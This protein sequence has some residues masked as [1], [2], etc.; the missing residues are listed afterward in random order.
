MTAAA[1]LKKNPHPIDADIDQAMA[2]NLC[3]CASYTRMRAGI[4]RAA[5]L[6]AGG[7]SD[8]GGRE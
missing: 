8:K 6:A 2:G 4:K 7:M 1:L 3:R 5:E